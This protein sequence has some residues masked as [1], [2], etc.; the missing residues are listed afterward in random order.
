MRALNDAV[1]MAKACGKA[2]AM[3][4]RGNHYLLDPVD[5]TIIAPS[6]FNFA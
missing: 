2:V 5:V 4:D 6:G 1:A 3:T